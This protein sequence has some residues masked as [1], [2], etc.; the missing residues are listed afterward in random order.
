M[1]KPQPIG[2][3]VN[4]GAADAVLIRQVLDGRTG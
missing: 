1:G 3:G 4:S 2:M